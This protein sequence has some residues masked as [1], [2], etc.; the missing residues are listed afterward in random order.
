MAR[1]TEIELTSRSEGG[2]WNW[3]AV[4]ARQPRGTLSGDLVPSGS[5][6]GDVLRAE[7][8][9][10]IEGIEVVA[11]APVKTDRRD[12]ARGQRIELISSPLHGPEIS[13]TYASGGARPGRDGE[14]GRGRED[15]PGRR[16]GARRGSG[17]GR[18]G[19][20]RP[21]GARRPARPRSSERP[22]GPPDTD[23]APERRGPRPG[24]RPERA[25]R[26]G[27]HPEGAERDGPERGPRPGAGPA[28]GRRPT[29][30]PA[31][32]RNAMLAELR[33]EQLPVAEQLLRGGMPAVRQAIAEQNAA[34][35]RDGQPAV[36]A[37]PFMA[38]AEELLAV[39]NLASWKDRA[40][41]AQAAGREFRLRE[42]R[43]V[44]AAART[45]SLDEEGRTLSKAL[46]ESLT[47]RQGALRDE[48]TGRMTAAIEGGRVIDAVRLSARPPE[49]ALRLSAELAVRLA[50]AAGA[51]MT[52][53]LAPE[54]W[55]ALLMAVLESPV[56][57]S[58][59]PAGLPDAA[60]TKEAARRAA[61][62]VPELA[63]LIGLRIPPPPP[64]RAI[65]RQPVSAP[66]GGVPAS[67]S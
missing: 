23:A 44:V 24:P 11:L 7:L 27:R 65:G 67:E 66:S 63:K 54:A 46:Q 39:V 6:V 15:G 22:A 40:A 50:A 61:G 12:E 42:L 56:R 37:E 34:A 20:P 60:E 48:W 2:A 31:T 41:A 3:R 64:R 17:P 18:D 13:V 58:V 9:F 43:A 8:E 36:P 10:A 25:E 59:K 4:G 52:A 55:L 33:P 26:A 19:P 38:M 62:S 28:R 21:G 5:S 49:P 32:H 51:A 47:Q 1:V 35:T 14:R 57:R 45:V 16:D 53:D 29:T 30:V